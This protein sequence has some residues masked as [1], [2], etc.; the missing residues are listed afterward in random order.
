[1]DFSEPSAALKPHFLRHTQ[2]QLRKT[3]TA[4]TNP[5]RSRWKATVMTSGGV[6]AAFISCMRGGR[7]KLTPWA[8]A[9]S[10]AGRGPRRL[11]WKPRSLDRCADVGSKPMTTPSRSPHRRRSGCRHRLR[12]HSQAT[13]AATGAA[14][15]SSTSEASGAPSRGR[16]ASS[17]RPPI[18]KPT[19]PAVTNS[20]SDRANP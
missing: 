20:T 2:R 9:A 6:W 11:P 12:I 19:A 3:A 14:T 16:A 1:M 17:E 7:A 5:P 4:T 15:V 8:S 10:R 18:P 13:T